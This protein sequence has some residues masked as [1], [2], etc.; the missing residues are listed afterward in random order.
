MILQC[1]EVSIEKL[2]GVCDCPIVFVFPP[3]KSVFYFTLT[4]SAVAATLEDKVAILKFLIS[5]VQTC[6]L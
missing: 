5:Q 6:E 1:T 3:A 2:I 4:C